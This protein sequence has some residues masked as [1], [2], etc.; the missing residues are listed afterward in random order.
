MINKVCSRKIL[1][2]TYYNL[3]KPGIIRGN[4]VPAIAGFLFASKGH[5]KY[6]LLLET[7]IGIS[8]IIACACVY[9]NYID[10]ELDKKMA[11]TKARAFAVGTLGKNTAIVYGTS[12]GLVG[13]I[14]LG[15]FTNLLTVIVGLVGL[16]FYV[17]I[18]GEAKR[19]SVHGTLVGAVSGAMPPVGGYLAVTDHID[20]AA[21]I[22]FLILVFWQM[23]H[24]YSIA[25]YRLSDYK[26]AK[27]PVLPAVK[28]VKIAKRDILFYTIAFSLAAICL[29]I[30]AHAGVF[31]LVVA[32][33]LSLLWLFVGF[34]GFKAKDD[35]KW[36]KKM[37]AMSLLVL[38][39]LC[40]AI[41]IS[42]FSMS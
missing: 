33:L 4:A 40:V 2:K 41:S 7:L 16:V 15:V 5:V 12:L 9:N 3:T 17:V 39:L 42:G 19:K 10:R 36:A 32:I 38:S 27:L 11:R 28:G 6:L 23:P 24:F 31:Y 8:L 21:V 37:F 20:A 1:F 14:F 35:I 25:I 30:F 29:S 18:Y 34:K 13:F 22:L 26:A